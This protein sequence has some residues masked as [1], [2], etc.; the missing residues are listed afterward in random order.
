MPLAVAGNR[1][2]AMSRQFFDPDEDVFCS[3]M[4]VSG[5]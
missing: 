1:R 5:L 2:L 3:A 4:T